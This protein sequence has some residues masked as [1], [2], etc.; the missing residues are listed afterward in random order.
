[1]PKNLGYDYTAYG[2]NDGNDKVMY[3]KI[4]ENKAVSQ[5]CTSINFKL[6]KAKGIAVRYYSILAFVYWVAPGLLF[7][8]FTL[9][10]QEG[11]LT[12]IFWYHPIA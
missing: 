8:V 10:K 2:K 7:V 6:L 5:T 1:M 12:F 9:H 11:V 3:L 4:I